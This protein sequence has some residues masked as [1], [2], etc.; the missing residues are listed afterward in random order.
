VGGEPLFEG[1]AHA[2]VVVEDEYAAW[3]HIA[4]QTI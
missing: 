1:V 4:T 2:P 3:V